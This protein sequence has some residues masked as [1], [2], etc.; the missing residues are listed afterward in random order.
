MADIYSFGSASFTVLI[1]KP[2]GIDSAE[3]TEYHIPGGSLNYIDIGGRT[4]NHLDFSLYFPIEASYIGMR[5][6]VGTQGDL[7][8]PGG[9]AA[10]A[11]LVSLQRTFRGVNGESIVDATFISPSP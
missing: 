10:S 6:L 11:A 1:T 3:V 7:T 5:N 8:Y 9:S 4:S 2:G